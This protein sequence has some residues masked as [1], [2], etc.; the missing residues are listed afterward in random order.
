MINEKIKDKL[1]SKTKRNQ[2]ISS[3]HKLLLALRFYAC[4]NF[5]ITVGDFC[6]VSVSAACGI[7]KDVSYA[8]ASLSKEYIVFGE[9]IEVMRTFYEIA[10]FPKVMGAIDCTHIRIQSPGGHNAEI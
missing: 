8:I 5:L 3:H 4:G 9:P 6:G 1:E 7:L 10:K 2:A